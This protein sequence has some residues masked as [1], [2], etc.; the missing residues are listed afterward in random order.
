MF[1]HE[2]EL[3][4]ELNVFPLHTLPEKPLNSYLESCIDLLNWFGYSHKHK[5][6]HL[7]FLPPKSGRLLTRPVWDLQYGSSGKLLG[8]FVFPDQLQKVAD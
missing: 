2:K 3:K 6:K 8:K 1:F 7:S 5:H 4:K